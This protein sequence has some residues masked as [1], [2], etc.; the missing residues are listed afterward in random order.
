MGDTTI[1]NDFKRIESVTVPG[2]SR[3]LASFRRGC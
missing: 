1:V 3:A 2:I